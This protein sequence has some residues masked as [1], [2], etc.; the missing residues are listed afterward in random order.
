MPDD[1]IAPGQEPTNPSGQVPADTTTATTTT[2][3]VPPPVQ[4]TAGTVTVPATPQVN[5]TTGQESQTFDAE[6]VKSLRA[7]AA[8]HRKEAADTA[9]RLKALEDASLS[10]AEKRD[11]R[12]A[13]LE[14][15]SAAWDTEKQ[16]LLTRQAVASVATRLKIVD[17]DAA[18]ALMD[19]SLITIQDGKP[20]NIDELL[21]ALVKAKPY[22]LPPPASSGGAANPA[23]SGVTNAPS[24]ADAIYAQIIGGGN[25]FWDEKNVRAH[26][27]GVFVV[28]KE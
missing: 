19:R 1:P 28:T 27:G 18:Y 21:T 15:R 20:T 23:S 2:A 25:N 24:E 10:D 8:K 14:A 22:L 13:E 5:V 17:P 16:E 9:A 7:E 6:Y 4:V 3:T 11:K 26:G 12:L